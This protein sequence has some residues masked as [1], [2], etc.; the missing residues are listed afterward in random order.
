MLSSEDG[1]LLLD[2]TKALLVGKGNGVKVL[3]VFLDQLWASIT[4]SATIGPFSLYHSSSWWTEGSRGNLDGCQDRGEQ[5]SRL[6]PK[7]PLRRRRAVRTRKE[8]VMY[9]GQTC[10]LS[11]TIKASQLVIP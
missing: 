1:N 6:L 10:P 5:R 11:G 7:K 2:F 9:G 8:E 4:A 3:G